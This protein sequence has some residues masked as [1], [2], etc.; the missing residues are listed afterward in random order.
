MDLDELYRLLRIS[1]VQAQGIVDTIRD[2]LLVLAGDLTVISANPAF[3]RAF[4]TDRDSTI[5]LPL[6]ELGN[7]QWNIDELRLLLERVI[8]HSA[9][10]F[11][12][13]VQAMFPGVGPRTMLVSAQRLIHPDNSQRVLLLTIV[14]ETTRRRKEE[15]KNILIGEL[16]HRIKNLLSVT[17]ALAR[18][19]ETAGRTAEEYRDAFLGR[20]EALARSLDVSSR[21]SAAR[22]PDLVR[23]VMEPY[24]AEGTNV[25][26]AEAPSVALRPAH[27]MS[28]GM[29]LHELATNAAKYGALSVPEGRV[30]IE[31][32]LGT[33]EDGGPDIRLRWQERGGPRPLPPESVGFGTRM[34]RFAAEFELGGSVELDYASEGFMALLSF[35]RPRS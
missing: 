3:Y 13:E 16:D 12:Y 33:D 2:P 5:G 21:E 19:T 7:G 1:H 31:W 11:D 6:Y 10:V 18:Q 28:L 8:P 23:A 20:F 24:L 17:Q 15:E 30:S 4:A 27:A 32:E 25:S 26:V 34:I 35:P 14:D 9:S 29:I 22:L